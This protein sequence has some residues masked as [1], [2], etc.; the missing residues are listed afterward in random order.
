MMAIP[1]WKNILIA[2]NNNTMRK[3]LV[4]CLLL[5]VFIGEVSVQN[6]NSKPRVIIIVEP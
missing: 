4:L 5:L 3:R 6:Q 2:L 1:C